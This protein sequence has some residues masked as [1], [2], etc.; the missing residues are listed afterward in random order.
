[1]SI[2]L[3]FLFILISWIGTCEAFVIF[4]Q[5]QSIPTD[6]TDG[7]TSL[8]HYILKDKDIV[9]D[10]GANKGDWSRMAL[11]AN[12][13]IRLFSFEP[14][15]E[16]YNMLKNSLEHLKNVEFFN[17]AFSDQQ[18]KSDFYYF[19]GPIGNSILSG[20]FDR[21]I[22]R[23]WIGQPDLITVKLETLDHFCAIMNIST[24][25]FLKIDTEGAEWKVL[26]GAKELMRSHKIK[27][28][29]FE[30]GGTYP[31]AKITLK[32]VMQFLTEN[33]YLIF[34]IVPSGLQLISQWQPSLEN[35][36]YS[37]YFAIC[38]EAMAQY[39]LVEF[40]D[41]QPQ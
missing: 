27:S 39:K 36:E 11:E 28:L 22:L 13:T 24:I 3:F 4:Q 34:K 7:E 32:Q 19:S 29:Q 41:I 15:P 17:F 20:L 14:I 35:Y 9:F 8:A 33:R 12:S 6:N 16:I 26:N 21:Q 23:Q 37:N 10:I 31:D 38:Q 30:Y 5:N 1:M 18:G 40:T 2:K 25:D